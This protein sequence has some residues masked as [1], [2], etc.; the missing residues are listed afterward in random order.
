MASVLKC[1]IV[2]SN[3]KP[4]E[5]ILPGTSSKEIKY[6]YPSSSYVD[7]FRKNTNVIPTETQ[8]TLS[9]YAKSTVNGDKI[10]AHYYNPSTTTRGISSQGVTSTANDGTIDFTLTTDWKLYWVTY[11]QSNTTSTKTVIFPRMFSQSSGGATGTGTV[12]IKMVKF[13]KGSVPTPWI[14]CAAD[15]KYDGEN[16]SMFEI[17]DVCKIH[18]NGNIQSYEF[19]EI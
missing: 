13:E 3:G 17:D 10:R 9:F 19:I 1:G 15:S 12:S 8:Y 5:N 2:T 18:K 14:P 11:T 16:S 6:T 7:K 4:N